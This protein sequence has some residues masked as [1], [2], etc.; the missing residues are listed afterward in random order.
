MCCRFADVLSFACPSFGCWRDGLIATLETLV[1]REVHALLSDGKVP[2]PV[3]AKQAHI[4]TCPL[5][6]LST[7]ASDV[8]ADT[9]YL[10][11]TSYEKTVVL[12]YEN[13]TCSVDSVQNVF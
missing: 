5:L 9:V 7:N 13:M 4:I 3:A 6:W 11:I 10:D 1:Y 12:K 2:D 8:C